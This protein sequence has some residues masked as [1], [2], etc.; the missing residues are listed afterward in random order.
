MTVSITNTAGVTADTNQNTHSIFAGR[1][2]RFQYGYDRI[3][4]GASAPH[5]TS[6]EE[7]DIVSICVGGMLPAMKRGHK[8]TNYPSIEGPAFKPVQRYIAFIR[9]TVT[10]EIGRS[11][12]ISVLDRQDYFLYDETS[13]HKDN[14]HMS[15]WRI[16]SRYFVAQIHQDL[17]PDK[18]IYARL[19]GTKDY[20]EISARDLSDVS[21]GWHHF[22]YNYKANFAAI[23]LK[24][25]DHVINKFDPMPK[26]E[27]NDSM[28]YWQRFKAE[29]TISQQ[30]GYKKYHHTFLNEPWG[31][32]TLYALRQSSDE[33]RSLLHAY[34]NQ[35]FPIS[36]KGGVRMNFGKHIV[37][38]TWVGTGKYQGRLNLQDEIGWIIH[39]A[40]ALGLIDMHANSQV[41]LTD[42][43]EKFLNIMHTDNYDPD[44]FMRFMDPV[45]LTMPVSEIVRI[46]AWLSRFF[47]KMKVKVDR[48]R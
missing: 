33:E 10:A 39:D 5:F 23:G 27:T 37:D 40:S 43:G 38:G 14:Q 44:A 45:T 18:P 32:Q 25:L 1:V 21:G 48:L 30:L 35:R 29:N 6:L 12:L 16:A 17:C 7:D 22:C 15:K 9:P 31:L 19:F 34:F 28:T 2:V 47:R 20:V 46:D 36:R 24:A 41:S 11:D 3:K 13:A 4:R 8:W 26:V 42:A